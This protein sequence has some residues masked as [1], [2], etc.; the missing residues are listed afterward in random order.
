MALAGLLVPELPV[1]F[2]TKVKPR[3]GRNHVVDSGLPGHGRYLV[4]DFRTGIS[5]NFD[6]VYLCTRYEV[7]NVTSFYVTN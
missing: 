7:I 4:L 2:S 5:F 6:L 1:Y 3:Q